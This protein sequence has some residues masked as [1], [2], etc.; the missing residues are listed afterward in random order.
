LA[1]CSIFA[2]M[3]GSWQMRRATTSNAPLGEDSSS[4]TRA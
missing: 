3:T 1:I 4:E 2:D